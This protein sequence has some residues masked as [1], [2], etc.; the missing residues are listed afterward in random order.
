[1]IEVESSFWNIVT[2]YFRLGDSELLS[3]QPLYVACH[4]IR[5][6]ARWAQFSDTEK[7]WYRYM[8]ISKYKDKQ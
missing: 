3:L 6:L 7:H 2:L 4:M 8:Y 5:E 1:M